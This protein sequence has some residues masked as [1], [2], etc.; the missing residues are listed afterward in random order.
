MFA[1]KTVQVTEMHTDDG[2]GVILHWE[3]LL[4]L[5]LFLT[6]GNSGIVCKLL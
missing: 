5:D 6:C 3:L 2:G 4:A 1:L